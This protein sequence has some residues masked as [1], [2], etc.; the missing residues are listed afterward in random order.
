MILNI[1]SIAV[2][3]SKVCKCY[4]VH[5]FANILNAITTENYVIGL[6][7]DNFIRISIIIMIPTMENSEQLTLRIKNK[8]FY[9]KHIYL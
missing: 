4:W 7:C 8:R 1:Y 2:D 9:I 5:G 6:L 3:R